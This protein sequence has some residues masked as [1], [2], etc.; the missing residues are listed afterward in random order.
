LQ[1]GATIDE[2]LLTTED[3]FSSPEEF[4][5]YE[6]LEFDNV[7]LEEFSSDKLLSVI[8]EAVS[9]DDSAE[10]SISIADCLGYWIG[11]DVPPSPQATRNK[12]TQNIG[13]VLRI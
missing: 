7:S 12:A 11:S 1:G 13:R 6:E 10:D 2:L 9:D 8:D 5:A 3:L 4:F